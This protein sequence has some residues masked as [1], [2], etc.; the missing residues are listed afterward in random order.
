MLLCVWWD[1]PL[2]PEWIESWDIVLKLPL[3]NRHTQGLC[4]LSPGD[5]F[6][7]IHQQKFLPLLCSSLFCVNTFTNTHMQAKQYSPHTQLHTGRDGSRTIN[8]NP[9]LVHLEHAH[10]HCISA[11]FSW[12]ETRVSI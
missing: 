7:F 8:I 5:A 6:P 12:E 1:V 3:S 10:T 4:A 2:S 9:L 11:H